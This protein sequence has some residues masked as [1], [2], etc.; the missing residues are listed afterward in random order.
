MVT[1]G[2]FATRRRSSCTVPVVR[3]CKCRLPSQTRRRRLS[4]PRT[5]AGDDRLS[6]RNTDGAADGPD[7]HERSGASCHVLQGHGGLETDERSLPGVIGVNERGPT[8]GTG[9]A[10]TWNK[11]PMPMAVMKMYSTRSALR[12][13]S[14][15]LCGKRAQ[16]VLIR[17]VVQGGHKSVPERHD[18]PR[19]PHDRPPTSSPGDDLAR[20]DGHCRTDQREWQHPVGLMNT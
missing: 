6:D 16:H 3:Q 10:R 13:T 11:Q 18:S 5:Y 2:M 4:T 8:A 7:Q 12:R 19:D 1:F 14:E 9:R 15:K 20:N 17:R